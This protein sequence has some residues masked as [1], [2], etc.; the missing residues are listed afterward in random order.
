MRTTPPR[1]LTTTEIKAAI[2]RARTSMLKHELHGEHDLAAVS[3][4]AINRLLDH[5]PRP[6]VEAIT[7]TA[8]PRAATPTRSQ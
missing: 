2:T 1:T 8:P 4:H 6:S 3:E 5:L 7:P